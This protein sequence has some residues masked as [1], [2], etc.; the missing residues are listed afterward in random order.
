MQSLAQRFASLMRMISSVEVASMSFPV[1]KF[2]QGYEQIEVH[3]FLGQIVKALAAY[4]NNPAAEPGLTSAE[5]R[6][7]AF[8]PTKFRVGYGQVLV[9]HVMREAGDALR[10]HEAKKAGK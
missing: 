10:D 1:V 4:E 9:D 3:A 7:K 6:M 5:V 2:R 8:Q